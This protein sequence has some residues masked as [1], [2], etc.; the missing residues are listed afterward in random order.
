[1]KIFARQMGEVSDWE[2]VQFT[3][4]TPILLKTSGNTTLGVG[5]S[6]LQ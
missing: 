1:M 2:K 5:S 6:E 3:V 4:K